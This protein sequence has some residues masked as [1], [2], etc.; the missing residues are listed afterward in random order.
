MLSGP[1]KLAATY[2]PTWCSSTIGVGEL[3]FSVRNGK[4]WILTALTTLIFSDS[5]DGLVP[6]NR[7]GATISFEKDNKVVAVYVSE[8]DD[9]LFFDH[10]FPSK[11]SVRDISTARL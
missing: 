1:L 3:N 6:W 10:R 9:Q 11:R 7:A 2:S 5:F 4:R 8:I